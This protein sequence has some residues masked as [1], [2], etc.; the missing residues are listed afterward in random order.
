MKSLLMASNM[1]VRCKQQAVITFLHHKGIKQAKIVETLKKV[2]QL[3]IF[4]W[5][6]ILW[7]FG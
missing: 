7:I 3:A 5:L 2:S 4:Q 1:D 6:D